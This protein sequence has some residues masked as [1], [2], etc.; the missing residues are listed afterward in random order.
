MATVPPTRLEPDPGRPALLTELALNDLERRLAG[1]APARAEDYL[2][3]FPEL[4]AD[5]SA[6][7]ALV[8]REFELRRRREPGLAPHEYFVRFPQLMGE[9]TACMSDDA[10]AVQSA[11][12]GSST[13]IAPAMLPGP[14]VGPGVLGPYD[15]LCELGRGGMGIVYRARDRRTGR[16]VALKTLLGDRRGSLLRFKQEF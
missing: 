15:L 8:L 13:L 4:A 6:T 11:V 9:L 3:C 14:A 16:E 10:T 1:G 12:S 7:L 5:R 2:G